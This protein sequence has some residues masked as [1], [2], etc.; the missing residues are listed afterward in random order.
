MAWLR[1]DMQ[2][3]V[4][5]LMDGGQELDQVPLEVHNA[6]ASEYRLKVPFQWF[7][8][9]DDPG[10]MTIVLEPSMAEVV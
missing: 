3:K 9:N 7:D 10:A 6:N 5:Y 8:G 2:K 4:L 1:L